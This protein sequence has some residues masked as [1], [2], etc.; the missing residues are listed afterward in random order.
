MSGNIDLQKVD[1]DTILELDD[2]QD[3]FPEVRDVRSRWYGLG[4]S[5]RIKVDD[6][7]AVKADKPSPEEG[8]RAVL[9]LFLRKTYNVKRFG[10]PTW[11]RLVQVIQDSS[12]GADPALAEAIA[13]AHSVEPATPEMRSP[14][15][16][17]P[18]PPDDGG[19]IEDHIGFTFDDNK[20]MS[21]GGGLKFECF[22]PHNHDKKTNLDLSFGSLKPK[23]GKK[24]SGFEGYEM[25][26]F[27]HGL[28]LIIN[29]EE[30]ARQSD[31]EGTALDERNLTQTFR[32]LGYKVEV[33]RDRTASNM[34]DIFEKVRKLDHSRYDSFI[35]CILTHG[36]EGKVYGSDSKELEIS[37]IVSLLNGENCKTLAGKPKL[38]FMQ[39]CRGKGKDSGT[40]VGSDSAEFIPRVEADSDPISIPD[41]ADF[42][43]GYATPPGRVAW[44]DLDHGSWYVSE[45][46]RSLCTHATY[47]DLNHMITE[48]HGK[49]GS[50]YENVGYKQAPE[51]TTRLRKVVHFF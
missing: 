25:K 20:V 43:F 14:T 22:E 12:G 2:L 28:C 34:E 45:L 40:R 31:R 33:H 23:A 32:F 27:P 6:L 15:P 4:V 1:G 38:F 29:N 49:V 10:E 44:R 16:P 5:L 35:C 7:E 24:Q 26:R 47:A 42:F 9:M 51:F 46:C 19:A 3:I 11:R 50:T 48:A 13:K 39:A 8:L 21:D 41:E 37:A 18:R 17:A 36:K 30:F